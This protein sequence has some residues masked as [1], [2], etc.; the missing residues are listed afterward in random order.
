MMQKKT[1]IIT[2]PSGTGKS[3]IN[4][5]LVDELHDLEFSVS[6]TTR[7][8]R[9][10]ESH[11]TH[12]WFIKQ[13][14]FEDLIA[15]DQMLEWAEVFGN[16]YG[17]SKR[18]IQR[19]T[20]DNKSAL[21]EIDVQGWLSVKDKVDNLSSI[22][23]LPPTIAS[24][25]KRLSERGTE[26]N[27]VILKRFKKAQIELTIG[28]EFEHFIINDDFEKTYQAIK[29]HMVSGK[30]LPM[31]AKEGRSYCDRLL[32][33]IEIFKIPQQTTPSNK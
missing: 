18:E 6:Y 32:K 20:N 17:T 13:E 14:E 33:E 2:A 25:W 3:T 12:Y 27:E 10:G 31:S 4:R 30:K 28:K 5:R 23:V 7:E 8:K 29:D 21:L 9:V 19:I 15:A 11:G 22:F 24:L 26:T 16:Y 1:F